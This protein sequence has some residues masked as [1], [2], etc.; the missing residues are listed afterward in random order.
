MTQAVTVPRR[1]ACAVPHQ[2]A[3]TRDASGVA[4]A[5]TRPRRMLTAAPRRV[6]GS[7]ASVRSSALAVVFVLVS[8]VVFHVVLAQ[9]QLELDRLDSQIAAERRQYEQRR[10]FTAMLAAPPRIID[11]A[12]RLGLVIPDEPPEYLEVPDAPVPDAG[13]GTTSTTFDDWKDVKRH[14]GDSQP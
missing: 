2:W 13:A 11:E 6:R 3:W 10:L 12:Q 5:G 9:G 8:A 4:T 14:L 1:A 7:A